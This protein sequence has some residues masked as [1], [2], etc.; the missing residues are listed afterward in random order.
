MLYDFDAALD[1]RKDNSYKWEQPDG[2][3][4]II[5]MGTADMD[6]FCPPCIKEAT[7]AILEENAFNYRRKPDSYFRTVIEWYR[8]HYGL[9]MDRKWLFN[10]PGTICAVHIAILLL[11]AG[12]RRV[13]MQSP[14]FNPLKN[15]VEGA[16]CTLISNPMVYDGH[17]YHLDLHDFEEK[18]RDYRPSVFLMVNPQNPTGRVFTEEELTAL[19]DIC[20]RYGVS[21]ISDEVHSLVVYDGCRHIPVLAV[22]DKARKIAIQIMSM[23]KGFNIMSLPHA[24]V[25][26]ADPELRERWKRIWIPYDFSYATNSYALAAVTASMGLEADEWLCQLTEYLKRNRD[27]LMAFMEDS[28]PVVPIKPEAGYLLWADCRKAGIAPDN[29]GQFFLDK[30]GISLTDGAEFGEEGRG[31]ARFNFAVTHKTLVEAIDRL[32]GVF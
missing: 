13:I 16:G 22:S 19:V 7:C 26:I 25:S 21:I 32:K 14:H 23:S 28:L 3:D 2:R 1:H 20:H 8:R 31:F 9:E 18:V 5:G 10:V 4:D 12:N 30:A 11:S 24:I 29:L 17:A 27:E 15:A 6:Y